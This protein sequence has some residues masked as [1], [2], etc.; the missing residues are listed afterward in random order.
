MQQLVQKISQFFLRIFAGGASLTMITVFLIVFFNSLRR[1]TIGKSFEWGEELPVFL[2]VYGV[3]FGAAYAYLQDR[4]I[5]FTMLVGF[6]PEKA[7]KYLFAFV[8]LI[9]VAVGSLLTYSGWLFVTKRGGIESSGMISLAKQI[10]EISGIDQMLIF[11]HLYPYQFAMVLGGILL[12]LA[13]LL[14]FLQ[15]LTENKTGQI[16]EEI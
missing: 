12:T 8:D 11:G 14:R 7:T 10:K 4:H 9:M 13:A 3:M 5:K 2:A 6:L 1:Y 15:R 16:A